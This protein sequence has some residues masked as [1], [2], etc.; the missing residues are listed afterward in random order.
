MS[1]GDGKSNGNVPRSRTEKEKKRQRERER[2]RE[3]FRSWN[4]EVL[5]RERATDQR[6]GTNNRQIQ[7]IAMNLFYRR[8]S[9]FSVT[10]FSRWL[11]DF[12][13]SAREFTETSRPPQY[14]SEKRGKSGDTRLLAR[15]REREREREK[16]N[17]REA[18]SFRTMVFHAVANSYRP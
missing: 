14:A 6:K 16:E 9:S 18:E 1:I 13:S 10:Q 15:E 2:E 12:C 3:K 7:R 17:G 8:E 4:S 11:M 5:G